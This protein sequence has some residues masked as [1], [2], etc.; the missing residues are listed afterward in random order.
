MLSSRGLA[1]SVEAT[2]RDRTGKVKGAI[3]E[4]GVL[5]E[6]IRM[7]AVGGIDTAIELYESSIVPSL[8]A[9]SATWM[10]IRKDTEDKLDAIQD[11]FG[12]V[13]LQMPQSTPKLSIRAALGLLSARHRVWQSKILLVLAIWRQEE[14]SL[15]RQVLEEQFRM[16][17]PGLARVVQD[18]CR[19]TGLPDA[20]NMNLS[21]DK[22]TVKEAIKVHHLQ[23]L[24]DSMT[25]QKLECMKRTNMRER[26]HYTKL[27]VDECRM[28]FRLEVFQFECR[29]N[30][31]TRYKRDLRCRACG[32]GAG[33]QDKEQDEEQDEEQD[34]EQDETEEQQQQQDE[35]WHI[36]DQDHLEICP[37]YSELWDRLGPLTEQSR[38]HYF[39]RVKLKRL[40][41]QQQQQKNRQ[42]QQHD[43]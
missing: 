10:D 17:W 37:G 33:Q 1:E 9:N 22:V 26:R 15:A 2:V 7:Q 27:R 13:V 5:I 30:M 16:G 31:P 43:D 19:Q 28:A 40:K 11:L 21:L 8:M 38:I 42:Q 24:K 12:K 20:T 23:F 41:Q 6:D 32:P 25:G 18:I 14:G 29:A 35:E 4:L 34:K 36:E 39:M 3:Y